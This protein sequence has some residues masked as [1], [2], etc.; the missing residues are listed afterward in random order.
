MISKQ[1]RFI[2][3]FSLNNTFLFLA[4]NNSVSIFDLFK[5]EWVSH[6]FFEDEIFELHKSYIP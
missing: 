3:S 1:V 6:F 4:Y 5:D 2:S